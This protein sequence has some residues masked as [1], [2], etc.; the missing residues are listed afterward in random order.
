MMLQWNSFDARWIFS[1][2]GTAVG[3]GILYLPIKAGMGGFWPV[4]VMCIIIFP[5]VYLS[6]RALSLFVSQATG[7]KDIT[8]AAEE[9][10]GRKVS[11][12][13]SVLYFFAIFPICLA[14]CVGI[15]NTFESFIYNQFLPLLDQQSNIAEF[16]RN[17]Y[18]LWQNIVALTPLWRAILVFLGVSTFMGIMLFNEVIVTKVCEWLVY[19]LC[20]VL[21]IF[22]LYLIPHWSFEALTYVPKLDEFLVIVWLTLHVLVFSFNHSPAISTFALSVKREYGN[23]NALVKSNQILFCNAV[24]LLFFVMFFVFSCVLALSPTELQEA[25]TQN[26]PVLSY[27]A[28][29][30]GNPFIAYGGPLVA[31]LAITTSFFGHYF[32]AREGAYGIVRKCCKLAGNENPNL[33]LI[34][35]ICGITMYIIM[36]IVAFCNP[37]VLDFIENLGGP[38]IAAILFLMPIIA[39]WSI[40][41]LKKY[42]NTALDIFVFLTGILTL[43]SVV[44]KMIV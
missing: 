34:S 2:F 14:Y 33:N 11:V 6:H 43:I 29:K 40:S 25:R 13:I 26:I 36:L 44:Y 37:S 1:L 4:V 3:A 22:S 7:E 21:F 18:Q 24:L 16:I 30:L 10:F 41:K 39:I 28:N 9:Y 5:M 19:P 20:A 38:I 8:H 17:I 23:D 42:R 12:F 27:F 15:T 32:G 31:F 35:L